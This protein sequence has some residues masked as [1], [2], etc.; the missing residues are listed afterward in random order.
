MF[1]FFK[2]SVTGSVKGLGIIQNILTSNT[3][4]R[5]SHFTHPNKASNVR[6]TLTLGHVRATIVAVEKQ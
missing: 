3:S 6:V 1:I 2:I 5:R 4:G